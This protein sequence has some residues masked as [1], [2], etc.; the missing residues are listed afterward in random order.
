MLKKKVNLITLSYNMATLEIVY[1]MCFLFAIFFIFFI[2]KRSYPLMLNF[3]D[4]QLH[5]VPIMHFFLFQRILL[6]F[7]EVQP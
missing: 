7:F 5:L 6:K 2:Q 4:C 1:A 3:Y